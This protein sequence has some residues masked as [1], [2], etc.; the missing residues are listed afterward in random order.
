[1]CCVS[2]LDLCLQPDHGSAAVVELALQIMAVLALILAIRCKG[3]LTDMLEENIS[4]GKMEIYWF[5]YVKELR[6]G[7]AD[8]PAAASHIRKLTMVVEMAFRD[9]DG[10]W[11]LRCSEWLEHALNNKLIS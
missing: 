1:M 11:K 4:A 3:D 5:G 8:I 9:G 2:R 6:K 10:R 7:R